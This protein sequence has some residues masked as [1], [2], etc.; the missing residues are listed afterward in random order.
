[1]TR[2]SSEREQID[3]K[4]IVGR[5]DLAALITQHLG[6][7]K[8]RARKWLCPF[9][10]DKNTPNLG[11]T[12]TGKRFKCFTCGASGDAID[13]L[14]QIDNISKPEAAR[15]L[16][17]EPVGSSQG[18]AVG[19]KITSERTPKQYASLEEV[20]KA[21][22][23]LVK[24][25]IVASHIYE[26]ADGSESHRM[27]RIDLVDKSKR[28]KDF[29]PIHSPDGKSWVIGDP[30]GP[31]PLYRL[32]ELLA[33]PLDQPI[34]VLEGEKCVERAVGI[35][36]VATTACHGAQSPHK[37][38][39][40]LLA[41]RTVNLSPDE[42]KAGESYRDG[43]FSILTKLDPRPT[44]RAV[45]LPGL[46]KDSGGDLDDWLTLCPD[47]WEPEDCRR[48]LER[49]AVEALV[50][51]L[52]R[53]LHAETNGAPSTNGRTVVYA[54]LTDEQFGL[55]TLKTVQPRTTQWLWPE[56]IPQGKFV[57][58]AGEGGIGKS[59]MSLDITQIISRGATWP[60]DPQTPVSQGDVIILTAEDDLAET[61]VPRLIAL[62][63]DLDRVHA[64]ETARLPNG[65][66]RP[67]TL[68]DI[69][70]LE[71]LIRR[72]PQTRLIIID[73][74]PSFLPPGTD[75]HKNA[76]LRQVLGPLTEFAARYHVT[77][78]G[79]THVGKTPTHQA[80][81]RVLGSVAYSNAARAVWFVL[82]DP[83]NAERRLMLPAKA[84]LTP[85]RTGLAFTIKD[86]V[87]VWEPE[88]ITTRLCDVLADPQKRQRS[89]ERFQKAKAWLLKLLQEKGP[90]PS[91]EVISRAR[92]VGISK[93][94]VWEARGDLPQIRALPPSGETQSDWRWGL[95]AVEPE[96]SP[97]HQGEAF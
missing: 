14:S 88:P 50:I 3:W 26:K 19:R 22:E 74:M 38:D 10:D 49:L 24:G 1:M 57:L 20:H 4:G 55:V 21:V 46:R 41:G 35:G 90:T 52:D 97:A 27:L 71:E 72:R 73:P 11:V 60:D 56:R 54:G 28:S 59:F 80:V 85:I 23:R 61:V 29:R 17:G 84:N 18:K 36:L 66:L 48:E 51:D 37:T 43:V 77:I 82:L 83:E 93:N 76:E 95:E 45:N 44:C 87:I 79:I 94:L 62:G 5:T 39:W 32:P 96:T 33:A 65:D 42:D 64:L 70:R 25:K 81:H 7:R 63:A 89:T 53:E 40:T 75:D 92:L 15:R 8:G 34:W 31:L 6:E 9:H 16:S 12:P 30:P 91:A 68:D 13:F 69:P 47:T 2:K 67:V 78:N 86:G 58:T